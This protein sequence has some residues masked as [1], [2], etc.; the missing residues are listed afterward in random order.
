MQ[1]LKTFDDEFVH[2]VG[3]VTV[4]ALVGFGMLGSLCAATASA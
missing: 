3:G 1:F 4:D 2:L